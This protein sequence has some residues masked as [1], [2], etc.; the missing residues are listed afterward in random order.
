[1]PRRQQALKRKMDDIVWGLFERTCGRFNSTKGC[2]LHESTP[3]LAYACFLHALL[4]SNLENA[5]AVIYLTTRVKIS[6]CIFLSWPPF[7]IEK[8]VHIHIFRDR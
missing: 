3:C 1:M 8:N 7:F 4:T 6:L 5:F 2:F